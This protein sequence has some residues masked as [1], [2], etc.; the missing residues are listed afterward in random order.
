MTSASSLRVST[1]P[2]RATSA[3]M[4]AVRAVVYSSGLKLRSTSDGWRVSAGSLSE[5]APP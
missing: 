5:V 2:T 3:G 1:S 4:E